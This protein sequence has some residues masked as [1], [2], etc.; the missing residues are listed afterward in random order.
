MS[1]VSF[2]FA[3]RVVFVTGGARGIGR[4]ICESFAAS[5]AHVVT[6]AR[7]APESPFKSES[8]DFRL[9]D[10]RD[11][12]GT[13]DLLED[14]TKLY[15]HL[16]I[17]VNNAG[18]SPAVASE[19]ASMS[20]TRKI[21]ELNLTIPLVLCNQAYPYLSQRPGAS[22]INIASIS[23]IRP[24]PGTS[25]YGAAKAGIV[26]ASRSLAQEW[27]SALRINSII[28]GMVATEL[29]EG[30][31]G[32]EASKQA[33]TETIGLKRFAQPEDIAQASL[34]L[35]SDAAAYIS[36]AALEVHGGGEIAVSVQS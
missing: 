20:F 31:Y 12:E 2:D 18:G 33:I 27:G 30:H 26:N 35:A 19:R 15:G 14:I 7:R 5:G 21:V 17:L 28:C 34:F 22:I 25:A 4:Q 9:L 1:N 3:G 8:I 16:D 11:S 6:C 24:S 32:D 29:T 23:D 10:I 36:G 13:A